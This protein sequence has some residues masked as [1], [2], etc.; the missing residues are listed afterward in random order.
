MA[1]APV[2]R[3][4]YRLASSEMKELADQLQELSEKGFIRPSSSPW[5]APVLFVKKKDGSLRMCIDY[6]EQTNGEESVYPL[7]RIDDL[8]DQLQGSSVYSKIDPRKSYHQI[9]VFER[10]II[11][12]DCLQKIDMDLCFQ[13]VAELITI[14]YSVNHP[15]K[16]NVVAD[17]LSRKEREPPLRVRA[18]VMT[19]GLDLPKKILKCQT[20][21]RKQKHQAKMSCYLVMAILRTVSCL[22]VPHVEVFIPS[23]SEKIDPD[24]KKLFCGPNMKVISHLGF[25]GP[26]KVNKKGVGDVAYKHEPSEELIQFVEEPIEITDHEVKRLRASRYPISQGSLGNSKRRS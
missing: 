22:R 26:F 6:R 11:S 15:R 8:F 7:P 19:I 18:L 20:E 9:E 10:K 21:A 5:G 14:G 2:A 17:A 1:A 3:A 13:H 24:V 16:A 25:V 12:N 4:P 23:G